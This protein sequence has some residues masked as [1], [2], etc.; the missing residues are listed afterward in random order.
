MGLLNR[1]GGGARSTGLPA[2]GLKSGCGSTGLLE[3]SGD[4]G[5]GALELCLGFARSLLPPPSTSERDHS[6]AGGGGRPLGAWAMAA[7][8]LGYDVR[9]R[10]QQRTTVFIVDRYLGAIE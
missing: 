10:Q 3:E 6:R 8:L 1:G 5:I 2:A 7:G 4:D 9:M